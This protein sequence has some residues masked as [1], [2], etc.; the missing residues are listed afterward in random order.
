[1]VQQGL[2]RIQR[3]ALQVAPWQRHL[4]QFN[5]LEV[6][7]KEGLHV[8]QVAARALEE[9]CVGLRS[10]LQVRARAAVHIMSSQR[11]DIFMEVM[12]VVDAVARR[13]PLRSHVDKPA[14][15]LEVNRG[16]D[17]VG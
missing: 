13:N 7:V 3:S 8:I 10:C 11:A 9:V 15:R 5:R 16:V 6:R 17:V 4:R 14:I 1:M 2:V 12:Y